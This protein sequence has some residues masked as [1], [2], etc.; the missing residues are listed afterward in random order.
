MKIENLINTPLGR[1]KIIAFLEGCSFLLFT[2]TMP[3]KYFFAMPKPNYFVGMVHG[4]L[5]LSYIVFLLLVTLKHKWTF[6]KLVF[7]FVIAF[8]PFGTFWADKKIFN[9]KPTLR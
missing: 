9:E 3:L 7:S 1:F 8:I 2:I 4:I 5:F 6:G